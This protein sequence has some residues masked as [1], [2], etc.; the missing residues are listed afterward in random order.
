MLALV[1][2]IKMGTRAPPRPACLNPS[3]LV[4]RVISMA[5]PRISLPTFQQQNK[6]L[7]PDEELQVSA[8]TSMQNLLSMAHQQGWN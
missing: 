1:C 2:R 7:D 5:F 8:N 6:Q 3:D 4:C